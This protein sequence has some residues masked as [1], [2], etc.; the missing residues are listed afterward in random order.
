MTGNQA[1]E[2]ACAHSTFLDVSCYLLD[3]YCLLAASLYSNKTRGAL[4]K[5]LSVLFCCFEVMPVFLF[6]YSL[7]SDRAR[8]GPVELNFVGLLY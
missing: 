3:F 7:D 6:I 2:E 4:T 5:C 1:D 8:L